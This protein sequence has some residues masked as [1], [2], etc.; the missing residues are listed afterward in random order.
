[1]PLH[2]YLDILILYPLL[3]LLGQ[4][5]PTLEPTPPKIVD[6]ARECMKRKLGKLQSLLSQLS[7]LNEIQKAMAE[8]EACREEQ[9]R[10]A[11][12]AL[13][14]KQ[15][16]DFRMLGKLDALYYTIFLCRCIGSHTYIMAL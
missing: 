4:S 15:D 12:Q 2:R 10:L 16:E 1:M 8:R 3:R 13:L 5:Q 11:Q 6:P 7:Q 14:A 9:E